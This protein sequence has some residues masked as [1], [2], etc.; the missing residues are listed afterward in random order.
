M[1][2]AISSFATAAILL[3]SCESK[4]G[5]GALVGGGGGAIIGG[6]VG[7]WQGALIGGA[8]G[9]V[10]GA[11]IGAAMD[12]SDRR[13]MEDNNPETMRRIDNRQQLTLQDIKNMS[14]NGLSDET[15]MN[16]IKATDS[17]YSLTSDQITD[18]KRSGV[19]ENVINYMIS[20]GQ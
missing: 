11:I 9:T 14:R 12:A 15:I 18:L 17:T 16:Q 4:A 6:A 1:K 10:G 20:T 8:V 2:Y 3:A 7:G 13:T 5:T 19:S